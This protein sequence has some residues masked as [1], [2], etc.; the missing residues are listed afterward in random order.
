MSDFESEF[1]HDLYRPEFCEEIS[2]AKVLTIGSYTYNR[3]VA[4]LMEYGYEFT[5]SKFK[6]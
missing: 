5:I 1:G 6:F 4:Y 2:D 3:A